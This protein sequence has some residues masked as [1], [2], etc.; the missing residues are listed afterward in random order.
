MD[1]KKLTFYEMQSYDIKPL[2]PS[3][4]E[5]PL[6]GEMSAKQTKGLPFLQESWIFA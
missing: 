5:I 3:D 2:A 6:L 1:I 4:E